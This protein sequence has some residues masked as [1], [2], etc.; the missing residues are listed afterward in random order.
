MGRIAVP[1]VLVC[2]LIVTGVTASGNNTGE[3][4]AIPNLI[5]QGKNTEA[6]VPKGW[7]LIKETNGD[8]NKDGLADI[9][10]VLEYG[11]PYEQGSLEEAPPRLLFLAF[12]DKERQ[13][14]LS[15]Q[16]A[17]AIL[18][19]DQGGVWGDPFAGLSVN[20]GSIL[21]EFYGGSN[22]RWAH[23][24]RF[25]YQDGG[26]YLIGATIESF[27]TGTGEG[28]KEDYNL[29]TGMMIVTTTGRNGKKAE[30]TVN[31]GK[32]PLVNLGDFDITRIMEAGIPF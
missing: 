20:R 30:K 4:V 27:F 10:G 19:A 9:A 31:R 22:W 17:K 24:Y 14:R 12:Q 7:R 11:R 26:W 25:R 3:T 8:L 13:Y 5:S 2:F 15:I 21:L 6:F 16:T 28:T 32:K 29:L 1:L 18:R 23:S